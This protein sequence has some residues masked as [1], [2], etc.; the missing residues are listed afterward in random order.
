VMDEE[1]LIVSVLRLRLNGESVAQVAALLEQEGTSV[2]LSQVKRA[3][4]KAAKRTPAAPA[5]VPA[6]APPA[7]DGASTEKKEA[8]KAKAV[9][10]MMKSAESAMLETQRQLKLAKD[11]D[12]INAQVPRH[13]MEGFIQRQTKLAIGGILG[14]GDAAVLRVSRTPSA[15]ERE[16]GPPPTARRPPP[17][18]LL[19][20][21]E[22]IEADIAMLEWLKL[23]AAGG[24]LAFKEDVMALGGELQLQRLKEK[25][26]ARNLT[27]VRAMY[28]DETQVVVDLL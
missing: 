13:A 10:A 26:G 11:P 6:A 23:A 17:A 19:S 7:P 2:P 5:A 9:A 18:A 8:K 15:R 24:E 4:S 22:R 20:R 16:H 12:E 28:V 25:R 1:A 21:Q 14:P 27:E 3:C